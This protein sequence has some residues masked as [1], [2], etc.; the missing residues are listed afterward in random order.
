MTLD[1]RAK[2]KK[3]L[4]TDPT[5][6]L[7]LLVS[8]LSLVLS[9]II[10]YQSAREDL[11]LQAIMVTVEPTRGQKWIEGHGILLN[12]GNRVET[13]YHVKSWNGPKSQS[14]RLAFSTSG[15]T[16]HTATWRC[17]PF[18]D[19]SAPA[20]C[21]G[22]RPYRGEPHR[23]AI[24]TSLS[25]VPVSYPARSAPTARGRQ[26]QPPLPTHLSRPCNRYETRRAVCS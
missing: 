15:G 18:H 14:H 8:A 21:R 16:L 26:K 10:Y 23:S 1:T 5:A 19:F 24:Q 25:S 20:L 2:R 11:D 13:V 12:R 3:F 4:Q 22:R 17:A 7:A 6:W 9:L